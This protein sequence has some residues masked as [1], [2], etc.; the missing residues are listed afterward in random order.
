MPGADRLDVLRSQQQRLLEGL[1]DSQR[2][3]KHLARSVF[4][5]QEDERRRLARELHDGLGQSMTALKHRLSAIAEQAGPAAE[6][7]DALRAALTLCAGIL[8]ETRELSRL[9]RPQILDDLGLAPALRWLARSIGE[10]GGPAVTVHVDLEG[11][12]LDADLST[13][14]FRAAQEALANVLKHAEARQV[15]LDLWRESGHLVLSIRDDGRGFDPAQARAAARGGA[16]TGLGSLHD[17]VRVYD[18]SM[19]INSMPGQGCEIRL[20]IPMTAVADRMP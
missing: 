5:V 14:L 20:Q 8:E 15:R 6:I 16:G 4:R 18:G 3:F 2:Q 12:E 17:R 9:L 7:G 13:L 11:L 19:H 1:A 10:A